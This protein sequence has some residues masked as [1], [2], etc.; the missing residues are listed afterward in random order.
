MHARL[1]A[2]TR[3]HHLDLESRF[4]ALDMES[5]SGYR[6]FLAA[7]ALALACADGWLRALQSPFGEVIGG[8]CRDVE[9]DLASLDAARRARSR[10]V[11]HLDLATPARDSGILYVIGGSS[12][13][14]GVLLKRLRGSD[15]TG[16]GSATRYLASERLRLLWASV[17]PNLAALPEFGPP[18]DQTIRS[19]QQ[20]FE[21]FGAALQTVEQD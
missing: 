10:S 3:A 17:R 1:W 20:T 9:A 15:R 8:L 4:S 13:G 18:A 12:L 16:A 5:P 19:A 7:H 2:E 11:R 21:C 14:A 6:T